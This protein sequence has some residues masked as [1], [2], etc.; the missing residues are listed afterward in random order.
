MVTPKSSGQLHVWPS[1]GQHRDRPTDNRR[2]RHPRDRGYRYGRPGVGRPADDERH[3]QG[4]GPRRENSTQISS[5]SLIS[6]FAAHPA[7][8]DVPDPDRQYPYGPYTGSTAHLVGGKWYVSA[9]HYGGETC[10]DGRKVPS[11]FN[12]S[13]DPTTLAG[14]FTSTS[15][16]NCRKNQGASRLAKS[17]IRSYWQRRADRRTGSCPTNGVKGFG[18]RFP[19]RPAS[20]REGTY[21]RV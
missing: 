15:L 16:G 13:W 3:V 10:D 7:V 11:A 14:E 6:D 1:R 4:W 18:R 12:Y 21:V 20:L 19:R 9:P 8:P 17:H 2:G 5:D